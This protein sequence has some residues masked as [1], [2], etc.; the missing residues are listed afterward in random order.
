VKFQLSSY[1]VRDNG[2]KVDVTQ[3]EPPP[4][5]NQLLILMIYLLTNLQKK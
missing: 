1:S 2:D 4:E 5:A 3:G